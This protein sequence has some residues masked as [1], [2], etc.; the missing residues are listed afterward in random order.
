M[1]GALLFVWEGDASVHRA[2]GLQHVAIYSDLPE[3][4]DTQGPLPTPAPREMASSLSL[5]HT[6]TAIPN[7]R[8]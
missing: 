2:W 5:C 1:D 4:Q 3:S 6:E 7:A 8:Q